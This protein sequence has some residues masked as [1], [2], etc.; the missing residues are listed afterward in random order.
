M[1]TISNI[2]YHREDVMNPVSITLVLLLFAVVMYV[3]EKIPLSVTSMT[4]CIALIVT[5]VLK[6]AEAFSGFVNSNVIL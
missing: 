5:N 1:D 4:V 3:W 2:K 6:P